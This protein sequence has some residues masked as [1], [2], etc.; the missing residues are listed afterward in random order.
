MDPWKMRDQ[1]VEMFKK[2]E[3]G[4]Q[5][6]MLREILQRVPPMDLMALCQEFHMAVQS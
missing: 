1:I 3:A 4:K 2:S 5:D 6:E